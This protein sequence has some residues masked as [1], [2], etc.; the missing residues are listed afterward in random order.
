MRAVKIDRRIT[1]NRTDSIV[2]L[3]NEIGKL[4]MLTQDQETELA[5]RARRGD[6]EAKSRLVESNMRFVVSVAKKYQGYG[7][8][9]EDCISLGAE[10]LMRAVELFDPTRGFK[11][12]SYAVWH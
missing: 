6:N 5:T 2:R 8:S 12:I 11:L 7:L 1:L 9:L 3:L 10:G 4:P